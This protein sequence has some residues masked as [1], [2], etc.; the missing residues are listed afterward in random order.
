[1]TTAIKPVEFSPCKGTK[2]PQCRSL[3]MLDNGAQGPVRPKPFHAGGR[4][5]DSSWW[6]NSVPSPGENPSGSGSVQSSLSRKY[7]FRRVQ[8]SRSPGCKPV[9]VWAV[10]SDRGTAR[11]AD[12]PA[13]PPEPFAIAMLP[14]QGWFS[15]ITTRLSTAVPLPRHLLGHQIQPWLASSHSPSQGGMELPLQPPWGCCLFFSSL[16]THCFS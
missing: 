8:L 14:Q 2:A 12:F 11:S 3:S 5:W 4:R 6:E 13:S 7:Q 1:M 10:S 16:P 15:Y 9:P